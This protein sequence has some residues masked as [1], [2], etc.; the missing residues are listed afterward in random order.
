M[1]APIKSE[2]FEVVSGGAAD[3]KILSGIADP[4]SGGGVAA[5]EGSIYLRFVSA[6]GEAWFKSATGDTD[7]TQIGTGGGGGGVTAVE[8]SA[9]FGV[10]IGVSSQ[11]ATTGRATYAG[12]LVGLSVHA[13]E[14]TVAGT[15]TVNVKVNAV[16]KLTAVLD[17]V[18]NTESN[19]ATAVIGTHALV[20][21]DEV[22]VEVVGN[23]AYDNTPSGVAGVVVGVTVTATG[24]V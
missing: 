9:T 8:K 23:A 13:E 11:E 2:E 6:A 4:S 1:A 19:F 22:T 18:T 7:W 17:S 14:I 10:G 5:P 16:T 15:L 3:P 12:S 20:Q 24:I 21:G